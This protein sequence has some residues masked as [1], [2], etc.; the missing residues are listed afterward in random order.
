MCSQPPKKIDY[1]LL[2]KEAFD[3][4]AMLPIETEILGV[5]GGEPTLY[6]DQFLELMRQTK[7]LL[8]RTHIDILTNGRAFKD[9]NFAYTFS[10]I[11]HPRDRK[12]TRLN[13]SH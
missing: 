3:L 7:A 11:Q 1:S 4:L 6:G 2:L 12:S 10:Q 13:S 5:S 8:P 9:V